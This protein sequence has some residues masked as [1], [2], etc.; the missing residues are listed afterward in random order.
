MIM[1]QDGR[2]LEQ[3]SSIASLNDALLEKLC[4]VCEDKCQ[5][6]QQHL[7]D[8]GESAHSEAMREFHG[9]LKNVRRSSDSIEMKLA[10]I[11]RN[12]GRKETELATLLE[13]SLKKQ[14]DAITQGQR[15][16]A[17]RHHAEI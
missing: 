10:Q 6:L 13:A 5:R 17:R 3:Q 15:C 2:Y 14:L 4:A 9:I 1:A 7:M 8:A 12:V 16:A 11:A